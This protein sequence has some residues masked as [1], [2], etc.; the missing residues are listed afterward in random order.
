MS[1]RMN[2]I[3]DAEAHMDAT[4]GDEFEEDTREVTGD[5]HEDDN[6]AGLWSDCP[7]CGDEE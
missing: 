7:I 2:P 6:H 5:P 4:Y 3:A 1:T